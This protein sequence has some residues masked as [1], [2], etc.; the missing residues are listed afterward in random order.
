[1]VESVSF[2]AQP[3]Q[4]KFPGPTI[5]LRH[6]YSTQLAGHDLLD[7]QRIV[8]AYLAPRD[9]MEGR[10]QQHDSRMHAIEETSAASWLSCLPFEARNLTKR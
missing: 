10:R 7:C 9:E 3:T 8:D 2:A 4:S 1:M 6:Y 5:A